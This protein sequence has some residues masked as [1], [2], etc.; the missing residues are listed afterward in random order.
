MTGG[1]LPLGAV[2][3]RLEERE[4]EITAQAEQT[5]EQIARPTRRSW[6]CSPRLAARYAHEAYARRWTWTWTWLR[7]TSTT[8]GSSS[9]ARPGAAS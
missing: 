2:L 8:S 1:K 5:R 9:S 7:T 6:Q 4:R 3:V